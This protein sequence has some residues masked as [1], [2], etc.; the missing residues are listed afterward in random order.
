MSKQVRRETV[1]LKEAGGEKVM[2]TKACLQTEVSLN[3]VRKRRNWWGVRAATRIPV[4]G[5]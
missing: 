4:R 5:S 3:A 1:L 2:T